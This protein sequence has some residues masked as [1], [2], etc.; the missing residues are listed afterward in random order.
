MIPSIGTPPAEGRYV[1]LVRC[2]GQMQEWVEPV[3][4]AWHK[5]KWACGREI[6]GWYGPIPS[7]KVG[8]IVSYDL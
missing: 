2:G 6:L 8:D 4:T 3:I 5:G 7:M 1:G